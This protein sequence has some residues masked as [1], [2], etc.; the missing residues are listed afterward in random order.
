[1]LLIFYSYGGRIGRLLCK[2]SDTV[3]KSRSY[4]SAS[5]RNHSMVS[6]SRLMSNT[7]FSQR[8]AFVS[9]SPHERMTRNF[10]ASSAYCR[11]DCQSSMPP[12]TDRLHTVPMP[13]KREKTLLG[14]ISEQW[15]WTLHQFAI[16]INS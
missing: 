9:H 4:P 14:R 10:K 16:R 8:M 15:Q 12:Q 5:C 11:L 6:S 13:T 3:F 2:L 7:S 1:M